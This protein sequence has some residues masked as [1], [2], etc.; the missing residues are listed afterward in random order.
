MTQLPITRT[1][2]ITAP[3]D[4]GTYAKR[5]FG[6]DTTQT[7][8]G[9]LPASAVGDNDG[10]EDPQG[11]QLGKPEFR[12]LT[13][14]SLKLE[15]KTAGR[16]PIL[17]AGRLNGSKITRSIIVSCTRDDS[18][19]EVDL[20]ADVDLD[21][22]REFQIDIKSPN[23]HFTR[24]IVRLQRDQNGAYWL[25]VRANPS[26]LRTGYNA[27]G[28]AFEGVKW[29][30][31]RARLL[32]TPFD[33]LRRLLREV[34]PKFDW[35]PETGKR[36]KHLLFKACPIQVFTY[37][38]T[39]PF[40]P[41][42]WLGFLRVVLSC[43]LGNCEGHYCLL[44]DLLGIEVDAKL[45]G[46]PV[47]SLLL[48]F[49]KDGRIVL[50]VNLYD[51]DAAAAV[52]AARNDIEVGDAATRAFLKNNIRVD[53]T[54]HDAALRD[55]VGEAQLG[56]KTQ[57]VLTAALFNQAVGVLNTRK[58][59][60]GRR[61][62]QWLLH[63]IFDEQLPL[64]RLLNYRPSLVGKTRAV[65]A[66]YN[67]A[68]VKVFDEWR[69]HGFNFCP[70]A[71]GRI[72]FEQFATRWAKSSVDR[73][74]A[75]TTSRKARETGLDLDLPLEACNA[76]F[77][78]RHVFDLKAKDRDALAV[79]IETGDHEAVLRLMDRSGA[80]STVTIGKVRQMFVKMIESAHVPAVLIA[81]PKPA[82]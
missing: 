74:V 13:T 56:N 62:A 5:G 30:E 4:D 64:L 38:S 41:D 52:E 22:T 20:S 71:N 34:D 42:Q 58:G 44:T 66:D 73:P 51:K 3:G 47:Q 79:A 1:S 59:T 24:M 60:S 76:L 49:R 11:L 50:S 69:E 19:G 29:S 12:K 31:E 6:I 7:A 39:A 80:N 23:G 36:I 17:L 48:K 75:R 82:E 37:M 35:A 2:L 54:L 43:P 33:M 55:L 9:R 27:H 68:A 28:V 15:T 18:D 78:L 70:D 32:R 26:S 67:P 10:F 25:N 46:G 16:K 63:Y 65:L 21:A 40:S 57:A 77:N 14:L 81:P 72:S 61:F 53:V 45:V 8:L